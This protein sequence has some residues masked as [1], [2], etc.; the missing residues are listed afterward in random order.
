MTSYEERYCYPGTDGVLRNKHDIR[1]HDRLE[2]AEAILV[3]SAMRGG[4]R[5]P[6]SFSPDGLRAVHRQ[7]FEKLYPWAGEFRTVDANK[8]ADDG[9]SEIKFA[10]G[11]RVA[12]SVRDFFRD[13]SVDLTSADGFA[14]VAK[15]DFAY[16]AAVYLADLNFIHPFPDGNGRMQR[17]F[18]DQLARHSGFGFDITRITREAWHEASADSYGQGIYDAN[19][20]VIEFGPHEKMTALLSRALTPAR[21]KSADA[22]RDRL[23]ERLRQEARDQGQDVQRDPGRDRDDGQGR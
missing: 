18:V 1:D 2:A 13:L 3:G 12:M 10:P 11:Y 5:E 4:L 22:Y 7:M 21:E 15:P 23:V 17:I 8:V 20:R 19:G 6:F 14:G 16:R 9:K